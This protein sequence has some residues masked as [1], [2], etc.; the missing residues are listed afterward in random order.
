MKDHEIREM[1]NELRDYVRKFTNH[2]PARDEISAIV[3]KHV[4]K[5]K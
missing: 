3:C 5:G 1:V 4:K 2:Q